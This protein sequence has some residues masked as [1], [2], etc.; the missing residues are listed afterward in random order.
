MVTISAKELMTLNSF[1]LAGNRFYETAKRVLP[2]DKVGLDMSDVDALPAVFMNAAFIPLV[3]D[4]GKDAVKRSLT[5]FNV[6]KSQMERFRRY[7][8]LLDE[9]TLLTEV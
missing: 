9:Q 5:F 1:S 7:F 6:R 3:K 2:G 4:F 8:Q